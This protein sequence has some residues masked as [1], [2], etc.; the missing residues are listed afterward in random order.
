MGDMSGIW[1]KGTKEEMGNLMECSPTLHGR[2]RADRSDSEI[3]VEIW[4]CLCFDQKATTLGLWIS[5][6]AILVVKSF[7]ASGEQQGFMDGMDTWNLGRC[8]FRSKTETKLN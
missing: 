4:T 6:L 2:Q 3:M 8:V 1:I 7:A 5:P